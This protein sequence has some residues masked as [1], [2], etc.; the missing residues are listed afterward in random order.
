MDKKS[1]FEE[2]YSGILK[3]H[4]TSMEKYVKIVI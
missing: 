2:Q 4:Y 3:Q 1:E